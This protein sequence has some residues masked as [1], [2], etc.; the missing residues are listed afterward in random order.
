MLRNTGSPKQPRWQLESTAY[1]NI[2]VGSNSVPA[3]AD[4]DG[5]GDLDLFVG[6]G[7]GLV[8]FYRNE[9]S[10]KEPDFR[11]AATRFGE[12][13][14]GGGATP[15]FFDWNGDKL[16][17]LV[18]GN[19]DGRLALLL[20]EPKQTVSNKKLTVGAIPFTITLIVSFFVHPF[21]SVAVSEYC[22]VL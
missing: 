9:G 8:I 19:R 20:N 4:I 18:I 17:D 13:S 3:V 22:P 16:P 2:D 14:V 6:N 15:A 12:V 5:D 1:A 11:L 21:T 10:A 7:R